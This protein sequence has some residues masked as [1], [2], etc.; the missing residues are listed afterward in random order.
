MMRLVYK[1]RLM[2]FLSFLSH[3]AL[4][5]LVHSCVLSRLDYC[6]SL[7]YGCPAYLIERLQRVQNAAARVIMKARKFDHITPILQQL[8]W[9]PVDHRVRYKIELLTFKAVIGVAPKYLCDL[10]QPYSQS[11]SLRSN[12]KRL[13]KHN[14][15]R[16]KRFGGRSFKCVAPVLWNSLP[17]NVRFL[18]TVTDFKKFL[19]TLHFKKAFT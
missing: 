2:V 18:Q 11:R 1:E 17:D 12:A 3:D 10:T 7:Y 16:L 8:H 13:L 6:N 14:D 9:L 19:K 4:R 5:T 15:C